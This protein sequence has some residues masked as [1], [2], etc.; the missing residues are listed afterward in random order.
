MVSQAAGAESWRHKHRDVLVQFLK[1][2]SHNRVINKI[3]ENIM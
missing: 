3:L 2:I 1:N